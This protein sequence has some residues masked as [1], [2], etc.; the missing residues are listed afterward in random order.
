MPDRQSVTYPDTDTESLASI[1]VIAT[2]TVYGLR[3][4]G[5]SAARVIY[6]SVA[7]SF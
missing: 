2:A 5:A 1:V 7:Q 6:F 3:G 4:A